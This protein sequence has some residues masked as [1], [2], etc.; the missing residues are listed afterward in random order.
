MIFKSAIST[1]AD[2]DVAVNEVSQKIT[3]LRP[4]LA[5]VFASHHHGPE[6][7]KLSAA[8][9]ERIDA[10]NMIGCT[11]EG[12][13]GP[14]REVEQA[15]ALAVWAAKMP[16]V[17]VLPFVLDQSDVTELESVE[18]WQELL[19]VKPEGN[20]SFIILPDPYSID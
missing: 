6:F 17:S 20:P 10:R 19:G 14:D 12:V 1:A 16:G 9:A 4:D 15:P 13:I 5:I 7:E 8:I 11:A 2:T 18:D 3:E